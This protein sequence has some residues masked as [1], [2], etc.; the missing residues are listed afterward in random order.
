MKKLP[1][2]LLLAW[3]AFLITVLDLYALSQGIDGTLQIATVGSLA[4]LA[5][6]FAGF[7]VG[8]K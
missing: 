1:A 7:R 2:L 8:R 3:V 6:G 4:A 5:A